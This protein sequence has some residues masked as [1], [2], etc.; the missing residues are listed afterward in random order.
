MV[1]LFKAEAELF[2]DI[3]NVEFGDLYDVEVPEEGELVEM[4]LSPKDEILLGLLH[5]GNREFISI[6]V[7][8]GQ[9]S[10]A[11]VAGISRFG[12]RYKRKFKIS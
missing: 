2:K 8:N 4:D 6:G 7:H 11:V 9:P 5:D 12:N 1:L 3:R 10:F